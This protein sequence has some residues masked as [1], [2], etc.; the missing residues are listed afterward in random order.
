MIK[1]NDTKCK[2]N[3]KDMRIS[4]NPQSLKEALNSVTPFDWSNN[5]VRGKTKVIVD[6]LEDS[7]INVYKRWYNI[8]WFI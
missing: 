6:V 7:N 3:F 5:V 2:I 8:N 1:T 4:N